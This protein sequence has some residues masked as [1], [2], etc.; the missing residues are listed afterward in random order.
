VLLLPAYLQAG[1]GT[2][3]AGTA[4]GAYSGERDSLGPILS[5]FYYPRRERSYGQAKKRSRIYVAKTVSSMILSIWWSTDGSL[6]SGT[7]PFKARLDN[8]ALNSY[9]M[10]W[11]VDGG[12]TEPD[13]R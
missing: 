4:L 1:M 13:E 12:Q 3:L 2:S 8:V 10:Y 5:E 6:L 11:S 7:Q 9:N